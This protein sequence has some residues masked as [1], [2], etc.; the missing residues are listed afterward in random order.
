MKQDKNPHEL[1]KSIE[2]N[3]LVKVIEN[4]TTPLG[5]RVSREK[6]KRLNRGLKIMALGLI[7][8]ILA[9]SFDVI[10]RATPDSVPISDETLEAYSTFFGFVI[11]I[12]LLAGIYTLYSARSK[13]IMKDIREDELLSKE[14]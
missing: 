14:L 1:V 7:L 3:R 2:S 5:I 8:E 4:E 9:V 11:T 13:F 6:A 12:V 10:A